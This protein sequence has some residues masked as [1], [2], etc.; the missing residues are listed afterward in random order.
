M[1]VLWFEISPP[2]RF[3]FEKSPEAGWQDALE[4]IVSSCPH[5]ELGIAFEYSEEVDKKI[6]NGVTYYPMTPHYTFLEKRKSKKTWEVNCSKLIK[7]S[8]KVIDDFKPDIIHVFG[9]EWPFGQITKFTKVPVVIHFQGSIPPCNNAM[10]PP[11][12]SKL[13]ERQYFGLNIRKQYKFTLGYKKAESRKLMEEDTLR[14][15]QNYMGRTEWDKALIKLY[16]PTAKYFHCNEALR[17]SFVECK[18]TWKP[19]NHSNIKLF[20]IGCGAFWKGM[21]TVLRTAV[22]LKERNINFEWYIAGKMIVKKI[23]EFK[24][25]K[26]FSDYNVKI[27]GFIES[28][29]VLEQLL[30][31]DI[32][33][34]TSYIDNSP[35]SICEAQYIGVPI[36]A[37]YVGG[38]PSL[39]DNNK[40]GLLIPANDPYTLA[41]SIIELANDKERQISYSILGRERA[42]KRHNKDQILNDLLACYNELINS[43]SK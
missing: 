13:D 35:N 39:I 36:I 27:L 28:E 30:S 23:I 17:T 38:I 6:I 25:K 2:S 24:E 10:Y 41:S 19:Q 40:E 12:Y 5:I 9:S 11:M 37:T 34:H 14:N 43:Q 7:L 21:D 18:I 42:M 32:Y 15:V 22:L 4:G 16:N 33:V 8:L 29:Q 26:K 1:K 31:S 3:D 20:T